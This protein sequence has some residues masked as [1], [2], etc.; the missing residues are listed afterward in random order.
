MI[1]EVT[2]EKGGQQ[3]QQEGANNLVDANMTMSELQLHNDSQLGQNTKIVNETKLSELVVMGED[4]HETTNKQVKQNASKKRRQSK[5][6]T[7][8]F[9]SSLISQGEEGQNHQ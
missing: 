7:G 4:E 8:K 5:K 1:Q 3:D 9:I 6:E 2:K